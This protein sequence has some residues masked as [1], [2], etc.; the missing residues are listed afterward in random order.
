M[1]MI[2]IEALIYQ[3]LVLGIVGIISYIVYRIIKAKQLFSALEI[4]KDEN[5]KAE[6]QWEKLS[7][8]IY[9]SNEELLELNQRVTLA[10]EKAENARKYAQQELEIEATKRRNDYEQK[11]QEEFR[12]L[13]ANSD[14]EKYKSELNTLQEQID[15]AKTTLNTLQAQ[16]QQEFEK[17]NFIETHSINLDLEDASD[18]K[19]IRDFASQLHRKTAIIKLIWTEFYQK[20]LQWLCKSLNADK[21]TGIYK[22]TENSTG[23]MYIGQAVDIGNR[24]KEHVK[25]AL[26]VE[27]GSGSNSK[28]YRAMAKQGP[29]NFTFEI[30]EVCERKALNDRELYWIDFYNAVSYGFNSKTI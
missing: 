29:E 28:F 1:E 20:P 7:R 13:K 19:L 16:Q 24:W 25:T 6:A 2:H 3:G 22:I 14:A 8:E 15:E 10:R 23:R 4:L 27:S 12:Q 18:I 30:L 5:T 17:E 26:G 11:L 21:V 9:K